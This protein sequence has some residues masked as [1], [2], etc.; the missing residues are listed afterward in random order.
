MSELIQQQI[1]N[2]AL[3]VENYD[4]AIEFYTKKLQFTLVEDTDLGGG[5]RWVQVSPP[6]SN[7]TNLL[8]AQAS[9]EEQ[10]KAIGNQTGGRVFLFLQTNDF[11]RDYELMKA[12]GVVFNEEPREEA[13]GTVVVFQDLYGTKWDLLQLNRP[14]H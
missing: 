9:N 13:Y 1:G 4:D 7:G 14:N 12:K 3:V 2:I 11:W 10:K 5:K 8:I 6:N